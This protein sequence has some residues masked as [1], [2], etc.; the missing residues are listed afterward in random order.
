MTTPP[1]YLGKAGKLSVTSKTGSLPPQVFLSA[2]ILFPLFPLIFGDFL[3]SICIM[4][5]N[6]RYGIKNKKKINIIIAIILLCNIVMLMYF[7]RGLFWQ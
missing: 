4:I 1:E 3:Y 2:L 7:I 6:A 5:A